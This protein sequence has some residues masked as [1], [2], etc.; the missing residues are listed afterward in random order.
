MSM[1]LQFNR[2]ISNGEKLGSALLQLIEENLDIKRWGFHSSFTDFAKVSSLVANYDCEWC[3]I[4]FTFSR[5][6]FAREDEL[7]I[8][9][10]RLHA[11]S[12]KAYL[13]WAGEKCR[14]WHN[15]AEPLRFLDGL[16]PMD[17]IQQAKIQ[18]QSPY[19]IESFRHSEIG[20]K[21]FDEYPPK[22]SIILQSVIWDHYKQR[23]FDL[24]DLRQ[25]DLWQKYRN[26]MK[27]YYRLLGMKASFGPPYE[28]VC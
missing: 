27:E 9:Y 14:C 24:F 28:N 22:A 21:L 1:H 13:E 26:F 5:Q 15:I 7:L 10:G 4:S 16:S 8:E 23:L 19:V 2:E 20:Q 3:R 17:A 6:P 12:K 25:P 11:L 18:K